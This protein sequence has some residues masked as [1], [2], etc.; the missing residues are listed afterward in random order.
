MADFQNET[1]AYT[2]FGNP[3]SY[4]PRS[5]RGLLTVRVTGYPF[6]VLLL[7][8]FEK[9]HAKVHDRFLQLI[10]E[11]AFIN[12]AGETIS[13]R[14]MIIIATSTAGS[15]ISRGGGWGFPR[16][17]DL[18]ALDQELDR[19]LTKHF[20]IEFLNRFDQIVHFHPLSRD[21]IRS[22]ALREIEALRDRAGV[23]TR[24]IELVADEGMLDWLTA[25][26]Y[27][28]HFGARFLKRT[29]ERY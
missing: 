26:G 25:H 8:E 6:G 16:P 1:D 21:E 10:D 13:C 29:I 2:L 12:S 20:R 24:G 17:A 18:N 9:A 7:D 11:G 23:R 27:D 15:E 19:I 5:R 22:I 4:Q 14:S 3:D 28:P